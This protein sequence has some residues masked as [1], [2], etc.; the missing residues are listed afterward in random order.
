MHERSVTSSAH[1]GTPA[2]TK[3]KPSSSRRSHRKTYRPAEARI[4]HNCVELAIFVGKGSVHLKFSFGTHRMIDFVVA[5]GSRWRR[6]GIVRF[7]T[8]S[9]PRKLSRA[10]SRP[11]V[12]ATPILATDTPYAS[13]GRVDRLRKIRISWL[14]CGRNLPQ[15]CRSPRR[16][17]CGDLFLTSEIH[18]RRNRVHGPLAR[19]VKLWV[20]HVP[21]M[22][23]TFSPSPRVSDPDMHHGTCVTRVPWCMP[24]LLTSGFLWSQWENVPGIPGACVTR[25]FTYPVR[26]PWKH[27]RKWFCFTVCHYAYNSDLG[28]IHLP[29]C[30]ENSGVVAILLHYLGN[31]RVI[32]LKSIGVYFWKKVRVLYY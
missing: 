4:Y 10:F 25:N 15:I 30:F 23:G 14:V 21:G 28:M 19:Y 7:H 32:R 2:W 29:M 22:P 3:A 12:E 16:P 13:I 6:S 20:A 18:S 9:L 1:E 31:N 5:T 24:G 17:V 26:G 8:L 11:G 27:M